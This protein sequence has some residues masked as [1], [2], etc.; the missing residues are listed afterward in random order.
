M[1]ID[2]NLLPPSLRKEQRPNPG[3]AIAFL[4]VLLLALLVGAG[5]AFYSYRVIPD[6]TVRRDQLLQAGQSIG[7]EARRVEVARELYSRRIVWSRVLGDIKNATS[8]NMLETGKAIW[9]NRIAAS[10]GAIGIDGAAASTGDRQTAENLVAAFPAALTA[11]GAIQRASVTRS[12]WET[13]PA[14]AAVPGRPNAEFIF[15]LEA[16]VR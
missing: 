2:I 7:G 8:A 11:S 5:V 15:S 13:V 12:S 6:L 9:L 14:T 1:M 16:V 10:A 4:I 3:K